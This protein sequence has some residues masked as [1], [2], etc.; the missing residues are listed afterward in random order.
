NEADSAARVLVLALATPVAFAWPIGK[1]FSKPDFWSQDLSF[2][3][4][5][6]V[7]PITSTDLVLIKMKVAAVSAVL[8]WLLIL[9]FLSV[10]LPL[11]GNLEWLGRAGLLIQ[12]TYGSSLLPPFA[13]ALLLL[14]AGVVLT[15]RFLVSGLWLGLSGNKK[16]FVAS[17]LPYASFPFVFIIGLL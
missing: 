12:G 7:R 4:F 16:V 17:T 11:W 5:I 1:G 14:V 3:T 13:I 8:S 9:V 15:W 10:W 6:A 2:S